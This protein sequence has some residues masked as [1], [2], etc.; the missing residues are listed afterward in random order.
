MLRFIFSSRFAAATLSLTFLVSVFVP[1]V[2]TSAA[3]G[4]RAAIRTSGK[5]TTEGPPFAFLC[6]DSNQVPDL[7]Q[8]ERALLKWLPVDDSRQVS[9]LEVRQEAGEPIAISFTFDGRAFAAGLIDRSIPQEDLDYA[10]GNSF[11]WPGAAE[12]LERHNCHL[13]VTALGDYDHPWQRALRLSEVMAACIEAFEGSLGV[14][15]GHASVVHAPEFF[16]QGVRESGDEMAR[17][18]VELWT[19]FLRTE[20]DDKTADMYT[21]GLDVF[22]CMEF[23]I[24]A[25]KQSM[26]EMFEMLIGMS[27]YVIFHGNVI[28]DG[29][30]VGGNEEEKIVT[31]YAHSVIGRPA[32]VVAVDF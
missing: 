17:L 25:S 24:V 26:E 2:S 13:I 10:C 9:D 12:V 18:P 5:K 4:P 7:D 30:T 8:V 16:L 1:S 22:G 21:D 3:D 11:F 31:H 27:R 15:W 19:G 28:R 23:E 14:Y 6:L 29:D 32:R 20:R